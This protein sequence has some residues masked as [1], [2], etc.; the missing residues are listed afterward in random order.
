MTFT[1]NIAGEIARNMQGGFVA[2]SVTPLAILTNYDL[3]RLRVFAPRALAGLDDARA[4]ESI[5]AAI[6]QLFAIE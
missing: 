1:D 4:A 3:P 6:R 2:E 5:A